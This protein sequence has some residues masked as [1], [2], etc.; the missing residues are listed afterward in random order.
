MAEM[1]IMEDQAQ[2]LALRK[3]ID[4]IDDQMLGLINQRASLA[5][6]I[7]AL[8][9]GTVYRAEREAQVM[10]RMADSNPGPLDDKSVM[11]LYR[12]IMSACLAME[13]PL[14]VA[15][16]GP[17]G[18]FSQA[19]ALR[20]FGHAAQL[21]AFL[22][23]DDVFR[24]VETGVTDYGVVPIENSTEGA[25]NRTLDLLQQTPLHLSG[26]IDLPVHQSLL[27]KVNGLAGVRVLYSHGQSLAQ[28]HQWLNQHVPDVPRIAVASNA[29][30]ARLA[31]EDAS[32]LAV[33]GDLAAEQYGLQHL[34]DR[35]EDQADNTTR[36]VVIATQDVD[37][38]SGRD[39]TSLI[40]SRPNEPG[41]IVRLLKPFS[42]HGISLTKLESRPARLAVRQQGRNE[43]V[44]EYVF[45]VDIEG[46]RSEPVVQ[47]AL[48]AVQDE[49][50]LVKML[51][52][53][54]RN[55]L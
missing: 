44:W 51:G 39:K 36:F 37:K 30:A 15:Y 8:K 38:P 28:C 14:S 21:Q 6:Q 12:E 53:Y 20:Q 41:A 17:E 32:V 4:Q 19:A 47:R 11:Y 10:Q 43:T 34:H 16:L 33:A 55:L 13:R 40:L 1:T 3:E 24:A 49:A 35:I 23:I 50:S 31:A 42:D 27:R 29:E 9:N 45:F 52:S 22:S 5:H 7:G 2:L 25:V 46:H 54:P 18:T 26:E 48:Q